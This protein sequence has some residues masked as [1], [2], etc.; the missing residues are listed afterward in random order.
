MMA[1]VDDEGCATGSPFS[2]RGL[3]GEGPGER[4]AEVPPSFRHPEVEASSTLANPLSRHRAP[5]GI[6]TRP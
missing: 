3:R 2:A 5:P 4:L 1:S 6:S